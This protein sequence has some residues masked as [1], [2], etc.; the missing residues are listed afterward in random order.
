MSFPYP[1]LGPYAAENNP[2][3]EPQYYAPSRF[4]ITAITLGVSTTITTNV[5]HNYV[6]GQQIR[7][8][9]PF[10]YGSYQLDEQTGFV[11]S[12][13]NPNQVVVDINSLNA[14]AFIPTPTFGPTPPQIVAIGD[15][16]SG[17][18]NDD[19]RMNNLTFIPGSFINISPL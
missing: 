14:N 9:I 3:I 7:L 11:T 2:P 10:F 6:I 13:P 5:D 19:G 17:A 4:E 1:Y 15:I 8:L 18:I 16:N 12:I